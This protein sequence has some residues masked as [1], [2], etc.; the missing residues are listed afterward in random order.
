MVAEV[1]ESITRRGH[2][3]KTATLDVTD[4]EAVKA[5][6]NDTAATYGRLD[7]IFNNAGIAVGGE[8]RDCSIDDWRNVLDVNLPGVVNGVAAAYPLMVKQGFGHDAGGVCFRNFT[9]RGTE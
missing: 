4:A 2:R 1:V 6:V 8:V 9:G 3:A 5:L 7:Y